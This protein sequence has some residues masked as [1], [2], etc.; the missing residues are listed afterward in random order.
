MIY[1]VKMRAKKCGELKLKT[2]FLTTLWQPV[3]LFCGCEE[4]QATL[5]FRR[6]LAASASVMT[7][8]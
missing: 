4:D 5:I 7:D 2:G 6:S 3:C 1:N 8:Q